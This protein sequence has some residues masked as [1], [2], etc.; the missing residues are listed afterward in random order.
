VHVLVATTGVLPPVT[1]A[2]VCARLLDRGGKVSVITVVAVP[3]DFLS[4]LDE[5]GRRSLLDDG[6]RPPVDEEK[7]AHY[8]EE[9]GR[10]AVEPLVAALRG[11]GM[12]PSVSIL[13]G[14]DVAGVIVS[15]AIDRGADLVVMGATRRLFTEHSWES[16]S[17][18]VLEKLPCPLLLVPPVRESDPTSVKPKAD[19]PGDGQD[20]SDWSD[21]AG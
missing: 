17:A 1:T 12:E 19:P 6:S 8:L 10:R 9:R 21:S 2:T 11:H 14:T 4:G 3:L 13:D 7:V 18:R 20:W 16:V 5:E 15:T